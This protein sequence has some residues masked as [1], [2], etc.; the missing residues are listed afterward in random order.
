MI[1]RRKKFLC[2]A[3]LLLCLNAASGTGYCSC[4][5]APDKKLHLGAGI[6]IGAG[7]YY[8]CPSLEE[9]VF[10][11]SYV[12]PAFW[13]I[14]M[15]SL[16][17]AGKEIIYDDMMG[18]GYADVHDFYYTAAGGVISGLTLFAIESILDRGN[19][20][21]LVVADPFLKNFS[22]AFIRAY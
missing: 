19:N 21:L 16:A 15:A 17:G 20:S 5:I 22:V 8:I 13:S 6:I 12:H 3:C 2:L 7:S 1:L 18:R 10:D 4:R 14:G 9:L 11:N